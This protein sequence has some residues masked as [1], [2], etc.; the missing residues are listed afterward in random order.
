M[1]Y[2]W[3][4]EPDIYIG[5]DIHKRFVLGVSGNNPLICF[6]VNPS[7]ANNQYADK[8]LHM[9]EQIAKR[10]SFDSWIMFNVYPYRSTNPKCLPCTRSEDLHNENLRHIENYLQKSNLTLWA[11]W[12]EPITER[13]YLI[14]C[15]FDIY[16]IADKYSCQFIAFGK[17]VNGKIIST[18]RHNHPRHPSRLPLLAKPECFD[19]THYWAK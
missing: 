13:D 4:I 17:E 5:D 1:K 12:G 10:N 18:T 8:T 6:G 7:I 19:I 11:A 9:V 15:L 16:S 2:K 3:E 14:N